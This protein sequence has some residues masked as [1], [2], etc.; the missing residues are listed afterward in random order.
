LWQGKP[1]LDESTIQHVEC[2]SLS[3]IVELVWT[4]LPSGTSELEHLGLTSKS[5]DALGGY[6]VQRSSD[7]GR[8][9]LAQAL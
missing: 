2:Q 5:L 8:E 7:A 6:L 3:G 1:A 9:I 4:L